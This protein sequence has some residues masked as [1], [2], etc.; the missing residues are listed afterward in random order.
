MYIYIDN[1]NNIIYYNIYIN[2]IIL[3]I[4]YKNA[5]SIFLAFKAGNLKTP[6]NKYKAK[7]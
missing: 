1:N 5:F 6:G 2:E 3:P 7:G 4:L